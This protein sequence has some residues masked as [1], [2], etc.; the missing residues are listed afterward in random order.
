M[1]TQEK[2][3]KIL[4]EN[5]LCVDF[6][7]IDKTFPFEVINITIEYGDW[8]HEHLFLTHL[9]KENGYSEVMVT[10]ITSEEDQ[11]SD[12]YSAIHGFIETKTYNQFAPLFAEKN[13]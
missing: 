7:S 2:I 6:I 4:N 3:E 10:D 1:N 13:C 5:N 11:G 8:K 12:C 9:M